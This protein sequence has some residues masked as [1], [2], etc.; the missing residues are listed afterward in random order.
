MKRQTLLYT[1]C[2]AVLVGVLFCAVA[3]AQIL[4]GVKEG[5]LIEYEVTCIGN[6]PPKHNV[7]L[8]TIEVIGVEGN[9][10]AIKV[11]SMYLDGTQGT[12]ASTLNLETGQIGDAFIIPANLS[13]GDTFL[14]HTEGNITVIG[15]EQRVYA[16]QERTVVTGTTT[17][18]T[19]YWDKNT[20]FLLEANSIYEDFTINTK[21]EK[22]SLWQ[23]PAF[24][25]DPTVSIILIILAISTVFIIL[26][27]RKMKKK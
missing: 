2:L 9:E 20:G 24:E 1:I 19:F 11:T 12:D 15:V 17:Y 7:D 23:T 8:A 21:A 14:E 4:V 22:T 13:A 18:T 25:V 3:S 10:I 26:M 27:I 16:G 6:V 5:D